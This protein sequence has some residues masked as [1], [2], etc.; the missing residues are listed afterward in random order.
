VS[1]RTE[2]LKKQKEEKELL[3]KEVHHRVKNNLQ[4]ISSLLSIQASY[5]KDKKVL[6]MFQK[7]QDRIKS[8]SL[9]HEKMYQSSDLAH[10]N[11]TEYINLLANNL[12]SSY[13][14]DKHIKPDIRISV[15]QLSIDT[16]I[17]I[18]LIINE[19]VTNS[20]KYAFEDK[21]TGKISISLDVTEDRN[22]KL[23]VGDNGIGIKDDISFE[24]PIS[25]GM[26][27]IK[28]LVEQIDGEIKKK[29]QKGT[30]YMILFKG[31][32]KDKII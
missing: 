12:I 30:V 8:M 23:I 2:E 31:L 19:L 28:I 15:K 5:I 16:L 25:M 7:S 24:K 1:S 3:L 18:G 11:L 21:S 17:P 32:G 13:S 9:I 20:I 14:I 4:V 29:D 10:I 27:L 6:S 22:Y 26:E